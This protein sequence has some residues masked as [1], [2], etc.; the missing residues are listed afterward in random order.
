MFATFDCAKRVIWQVGVRSP[1]WLDHAR[2][3]DLS[4]TRFRRQPLSVCSDAGC[5]H[6]SPLLFEGFDRRAS[7]SCLLTRADAELR[8]RTNE[9]GNSLRIQISK[10]RSWAFVAMLCPCL[11]D[12]R[13]NIGS[14][15][16]LFARRSLHHEV[17]IVAVDRIAFSRSQQRSIAPPI[18][19]NRIT[20]CSHCRRA[21]VLQ[22]Q[23]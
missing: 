2:L 22:R 9:L 4:F 11:R 18:A 23:I 15:L 6:R 1:P 13:Y 3:Y 20:A 14:E 12:G 21:F 17:R 16:W 19:R 8:G 10:R 7:E 5:H